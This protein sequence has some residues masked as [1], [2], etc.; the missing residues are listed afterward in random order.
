MVSLRPAATDKIDKFI[1]ASFVFFQ[2]SIKSI[3]QQETLTLFFSILLLHF[4]GKARSCV[5]VKWAPL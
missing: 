2:N 3:Q 5:S 1:P 4:E